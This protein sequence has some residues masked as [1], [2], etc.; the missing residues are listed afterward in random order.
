MFGYGAVIGIYCIPIVAAVF[1]IFR[2][3]DP[4][5]IFLKDILGLT[6]QP[7]RV[8]ASAAFGLF[9]LGGV[10]GNESYQLDQGRVDWFQKLI[11]KLLKK[12]PVKNRV[13]NTN[14]VE[15][16]L[17][18][19]PMWFD[20]SII[21]RIFRNYR[22]ER[23]REIN[24]KFRE[25]L[26]VHNQLFIIMTSCNYCARLFFPVLAFLGISVAVA[27]NYAVIMLYE[28]MELYLYLFA[29]FID[30]ASFV[31]IFFYCYHGAM[32]LVL[33]TQ[34]IEFWKAKK[35][36]KAEMKSARA[37]LP[38]ACMLGHF[39][40]AKKNTFLDIM[41]NILDY[42]VSFIVF[43][44]SKLPGAPS[45]A[46]IPQ[47]PEMFGYGAVA[48]FYCIPIV[49]A[50]F[51]IFRNYDPFSIFLKDILGFSE[52][53]RRV[54]ASA[55]FGLF[56]LGG[57]PGVS[58]E[59]LLM[60]TCMLVFGKLLKH[61]ED[62]NKDDSYQL[63][64][65]R[66]DWFQRMVMKLLKKFPVKN[67]VWNTNEVEDRLN[68]C[69]MWFDNS[70]TTPIFRSIRNKHNREINQKFREQV[71]VHNQL[72]ILMTSCNYAARLFF[73]LFAFLGISV[74]VAMNYAVIMLYEEMDLYLYL[75][76]CFIDTVCFVLIY[77]YCYHGAM[78]LVLSTR[79]IEFWKAKKMGKEEMKSARAMLPIACML[80]NF[81]S[82]K[83]DTFL[84]IMS[85]ILDYTVSFIVS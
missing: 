53:P 36:G 80:G 5:S 59:I 81:F 23:N 24:Q 71:H 17:T 68:N 63:D 15:D 45:L 75:F 51:P 61:L 76:V 10:P 26:H 9:A 58:C 74:C 42:T 33:S 67:R 37:M 50:I 52:L 41:S 72:F 3:Y 30:I 40:S 43:F 4:F 28:E 39:F 34:F 25:Q 83:R 60:A 29:C 55:V 31:L 14:E 8:L 27:M 22:N 84:D 18:N 46:R 6:E 12:L 20:N 62:L 1:P 48:G 77:F 47:F 57:V 19:C 16:K 49:A 73:P 11:M 44:V 85:N 82:A 70:I 38:V 32:P 69:P 7:R 35:M 13:W 54:L 56:V 66:V 2:N 65:K 79:L 21:A 78:P 64:G